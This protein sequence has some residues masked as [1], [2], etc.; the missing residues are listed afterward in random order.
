MKANGVPQQLDPRASRSEYEARVNRV[1]DY[2]EAH[3]DAPLSLRELAKIAHFSPY[4]FHRIFAAMI[5][6]PLGQFVQR[7]RVEKAAR[8]L[9]AEPRV[10]VTEIALDCGFS[11]S[12]T[13]ARAFKLA[14]GMSASAFRKRG[15]AVR[16]AAGSNICKV[17]RKASNAGLEGAWYLDRQTIHPT[18]RISVAPHSG[19]L[20]AHI[21]VRNLPEHHVVYLRHT[22]PY[23]QPSV[24]RE[25]VHK[26][27]RWA[28]ARELMTPETQLIC[29]AHD[30]PV[31]TDQTKLRLSVC[32]TT[33]SG[34]RGD[35]DIG[36]MRIP[37]GKF[38][39]A[40][41]EIEPHQVAQAWNAVVGGWL[42]ESGYQPDD[43][44]CYEVVR[45]APTDHPQGLITLDI[46]VPVRPL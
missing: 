22:G 27:Q 10:S 26:L 35:G 31:V 38:A 4:H 45:K 30:S 20:R 7:L 2:I 29:V 40:R 46:C 43:R 42:P 44:P 19:A 3:L 5:G 33:P 25:L 8:R 32:L 24:V 39:V 16:H 41:F 12:A 9:L 13:F 1:S 23:G 6:E 37:G 34:T 18:W 11:S 28:T 36:T 15:H 21:E 17:L 14:F